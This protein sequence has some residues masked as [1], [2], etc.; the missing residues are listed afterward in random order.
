MVIVRTV[1]CRD[2]CLAGYCAF[3]FCDLKTEGS[4][5][6]DRE[7]NVTTSFCDVP[8]YRDFVILVIF[9]GGI[10]R[11]FRAALG[12]ELHDTRRSDPR[13]VGR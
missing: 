8:P 10:S 1:D 3:F 7:K 4:R 5:I 11:K 6:F 9:H 12:F 13:R 2:Y